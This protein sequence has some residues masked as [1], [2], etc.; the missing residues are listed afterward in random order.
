MQE[1]GERQAQLERCQREKKV[2]EKELEKA[3]AQKPLELIQAG[4]NIHEL[5]KRV[6][7]AERGRDDALVKLEASEAA[8]KRLEKKYVSLKLSLNSHKVAA[9]MSLSTNSYTLLLTPV[10]SLVYMGC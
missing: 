9:C 7:I 3:L 6:C 2:V 8:N 1:V 4:E 5:Q 10:T